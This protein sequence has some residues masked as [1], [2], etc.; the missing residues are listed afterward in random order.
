MP[1]TALTTLLPRWSSGWRLWARRG[2]CRSFSVWCP[3]VDQ[4]DLT[5]APDC[6]NHKEVQH[7]DGKP[8]WCN[9]CGWNRGRPGVDPIKWGF[10]S[11]GWGTLGANRPKGGKHRRE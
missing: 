11:G 1:C 7:R 6:P 4:P 3:P 8:P 5:G 9:R 2:T 10:G